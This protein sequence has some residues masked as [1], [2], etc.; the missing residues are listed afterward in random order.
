MADT[1][2]I[3]GALA[4][5]PPALHDAADYGR[6]QLACDEL[7]A[8]ARSLLSR[9][10]RMSGQSHLLSRMSL[11]GIRPAGAL[12]IRLATRRHAGHLEAHQKGII[13]PSEI[14]IPGVG[15]GDHRFAEKHCFG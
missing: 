1:S 10:G 14:E 8:A 2:F 12:P 6:G 7:L 5:A 13:V 9:F 4:R 15:A 3:L 11:V